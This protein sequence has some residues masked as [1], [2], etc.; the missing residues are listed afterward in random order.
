[1]RQEHAILLAATKGGLKNYPGEVYDV[2]QLRAL[3][4]VFDKTARGVTGYQW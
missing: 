1:V 2:T 4:K 3:Q